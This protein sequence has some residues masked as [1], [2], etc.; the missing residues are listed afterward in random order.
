MK[1]AVVFALLLTMSSGFAFGEP[2]S[3]EIPSGE[4]THFVDEQI[5]IMADI[6]NNQDVPQ[7]FAYLT[8]VKNDQGV[9]ISLSWLTG[10]LSP[11]QSFSPAQSWTPTETGTFH[12]QV[13]VWES[14]DNPEALSPP[15]SMIVNVEN[16]S[17]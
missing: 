15:L 7:N 3:T 5:M 6:S 2:V 17:T 14:I 10:S 4:K 12:I 1:I 8:Q 16:T 13:F 9:V 11:R